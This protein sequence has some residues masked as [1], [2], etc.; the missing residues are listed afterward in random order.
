MARAAKT[1]L[2]SRSAPE[3]APG[4]PTYAALRDQL[5][6]EILSGRIPHGTR[7]TT[8]SLVQRYGFSQMPIREALQALQGEGLV[9]IEPHKG[10]CVLSLT[11]ERVRNI[12]D[13]RAALEALLI[14]L[15]LP[16]L[17]NAAMA[18]LTQI[19]H[20]FREAVAREDLGSIFDLNNAFHDLIYEHGDNDEAL[21][22]YKRYAKLLGGLRGTY[23]YSRL[24]LK[25]M[26]KEHND[27]LQALKAQDE[28]RLERSVLLHVEG[29]KNDLLERMGR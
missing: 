21:L 20:D 9:E 16:N 7:L 1:A 13:L 18:K 10:A 23:G 15:S 3:S 5:R 4:V 22:I 8:A 11:A 6:A 29:A 2:I 17:T 25:Q 12:Y 27:I 14:R 24:R 26:A 19:N 28:A